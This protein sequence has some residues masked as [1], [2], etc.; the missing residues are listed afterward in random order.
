MPITH[1]ESDD[2]DSETDR[3][4]KHREQKEK[5]WKR[6]TI[7]QFIGVGLLIGG[8]SLLAVPFS[9]ESG[10]A[11]SPAHWILFAGVLLTW[12]GFYQLRSELTS[13]RALEI[14]ELARLLKRAG[15]DQKVEIRFRF[16]SLTIR[17]LDPLQPEEVFAEKTI[18]VTYWG[19]LYIE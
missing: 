1:Y 6:V 4:H 11:V 5:T 19:R 7:V 16:N 10:L 2:I 3:L 9:E 12:Y 18:G 15:A 17:L 13:R 14:C 8:G